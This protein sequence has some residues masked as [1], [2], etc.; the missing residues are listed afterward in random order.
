MGYTKLFSSII[1]STIWRTGD[2]TRLVWITMLAMADQF[3]VVEASVPGLSDMARVTVAECREALDELQQPDPDSRSSEQE[4]RRIEKVEGGWRL[5]NHGKYREKMSRDERREYQ[6]LYQ[7]SYRKQNVNSDSDKLTKFDIQKQK[8]NRTETETPVRTEVP[9]PAATNT[10]DAFSAFWRAY[11]KKAGKA[12]ALKVWKRLRPSE[13]LSE[14]IVA[15]VAT[16]GQSRQWREGYIPNPARWLNE[17]RWD[18]EVEVTRPVGIAGAASDWACPHMKDGA[19]L[20]GNRHAC[21]LFDTLPMY[22]DERERLGRS[23]G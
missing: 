6:R 11:P 8:Q 20:H 10:P 14:A 18:D 23:A 12:A 9:S 4:G 22:A 5:I 2:K 17:G 7:R 13:S 1:A 21:D 19:T 15:A 3:G 16:A